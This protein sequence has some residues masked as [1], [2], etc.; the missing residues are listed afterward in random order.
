VAIKA[1]ALGPDHFV[2]V[3]GIIKDL[4]E[5]LNQEKIAEASQKSFCDVEMAEVLSNR[6]KFN[7]EVE[8]QAAL[9]QQ[10]TSFI[11]ST[12]KEISVLSQEVADISK[13]LNEATQLRQEEKAANAQTVQEAKAGS[14]AVANALSVLKS[15][16]GFIQQPDAGRDGKTVKDMAPEM[17]YSGDY[18]GA[19]DSSKGIMGLLEV[20]KSDFDRTEDT[21]TDQEE[22]NEKEFKEYEKD[23]KEDV[24]AK[25]KLIKDKEAEIVVA[26]EK[27]TTAKD[28]K[29]KA[30]RLHGDSLA[31]LEKLKPM[32]VAAEESYEER[33]KKR[34]E[35]IEA[36]KEAHKILEEWQ[37]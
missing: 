32:C 29:A 33:R 13:A 23:S 15:F 3:R 19:Q 30:T 4:I 5:R 22:E 24:T 11:A 36:L 28:D 6:D 14:E 21:V 27:I 7:L 17:S 12:Q 37:G 9:I 10:K 31:E 25:K 20:I 1:D 34:M 2:K 35:E 16:Y 26:E 18:K 8:E